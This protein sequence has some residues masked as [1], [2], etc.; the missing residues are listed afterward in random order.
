MIS[1]LKIDLHAWTEG[2]AFLKILLFLDI[3]IAQHMRIMTFFMNQEEPEAPTVNFINNQST[4]YK[5]K[6]EKQKGKGS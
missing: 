4:S 6:R 5:N 2:E 1:I 3:Q